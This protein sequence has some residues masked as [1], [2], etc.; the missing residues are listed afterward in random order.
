MTTTYARSNGT[1]SL[2]N[3]GLKAGYAVSETNTGVRRRK[4]KGAWINPT[5]YTFTRVEWRGAIGS[6][7]NIVGTPPPAN[8][9]CSTGQWYKGVVG[10]VPGDSLT[11]FD[12]ANTFTP[13]LSDDTA[14]ADDGLRNA[15]LIAVRNKLKN[16]KVDLG[17]AFAERKATS[18]MVGDTAIRLARSFQH[19]KRGQTRRAMDELGIS[20]R[21][22]QPR[23]SN[24]PNKW[25]ELQYGWDPL[26][27]DVY[28][29]CESLAKKSKD[30]WRV[31]AKA[32]KSSKTELGGEY[33]S[34]SSTWSIR[35]VVC[36]KSVFARIDCIPANELI[37]SLA[38]LGIL[39]P[40][41]VAWEL[42][43]YS[44]VVDWFLPIGSY[45]DSLDAMLG[46]T[47]RGYS[48]SLLTRTRWTTTGIGTRTWANGKVENSWTGSKYM[49]YLDRQVSTSVP[50]P[51]FP[52]FK[53]PRSLGHMANGLALL[54]S[55]FGRR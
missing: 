55:A 14:K 21:R 51:T 32:V 43:P 9:S 47:S 2:T 39:N 12:L 27:S 8:G 33:A 28:G 35:K 1:C 23:G 38:S 54:A 22:G 24:V 52:S 5:P 48:S 44:F 37:I 11:R 4:P 49:V 20:S 6:A 41:L 36:E 30:D 18:K 26:L 29:A 19:L 40:L 50:I 7:R 15:A 25:L 45:L 31:T 16:A 17:I 53:D 42:V 10:T 3:L 13:L 34:Y 46:Y